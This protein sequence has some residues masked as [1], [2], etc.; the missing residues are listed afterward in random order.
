VYLV[1]IRGNLILRDFSIA[2]EWDPKLVALSAN[3]RGLYGVGSA[4]EF[5]AHEVLNH[6]FE[7]G[8]HFRRRGDI[9]EGWLVASGF[10]ADSGQISE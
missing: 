9:A 6:R 10:K 3:G 1:A 7:T 8:I 5:V 4:F 2:S